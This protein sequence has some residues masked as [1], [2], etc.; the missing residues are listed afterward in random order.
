V[1]SYILAHFGAH[2]GTQNLFKFYNFWHR[3]FDNLLVTVW[4]TLGLILGPILGPDRP[5]K[6]GKMSPRGPSR[7][8]KTKKVTF[9]K[10]LTNYWFFN[11]FGVQRPPKRGSGGPRGLPRGTQRAP[12]PKQKWIQKWTPK[13]TIFGLILGK[14]WGPKLL[15]KSPKNGTTFGTLSPRLSEVPKMRFYESGE[16]AIGTGI[17]LPKR[18]GG[19][20]PASLH[21][22]FYLTSS[23][24][25]ALSLSFPFS[26]C[27]PLY[28][29]VSR[30][31]PA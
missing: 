15:Q 20:F 18:N 2:F 14:F 1:A 26:F 13:S 8:S 4:A 29:S 27:M 5:K 31:T 23:L 6:G 7:A 3:F 9:S 25:Q 21:S 22:F 24:S 30:F 19:I 28:R 16:I 12:K 10:T 11:V 17:I